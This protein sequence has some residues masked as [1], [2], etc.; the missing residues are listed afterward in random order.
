MGIDPQYSERKSRGDGGVRFMSD[1]MCSISQLPY[2]YP[3]T[4]G[5]WDPV[6]DVSVRSVQSTHRILTN[7]GKYVIDGRFNC[8]CDWRWAQPEGGW[9]VG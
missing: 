6:Q 5:N 8:G 4:V 1:G 9:K 3:K 2:D 7:H